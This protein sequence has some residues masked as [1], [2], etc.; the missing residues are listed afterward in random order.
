MGCMASRGRLGQDRYAVMLVGVSN[1]SIEMY[2]FSNTNV[3]RNAT[4]AAAIQPRVI[5]CLPQY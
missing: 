5:L 2:T 3:N 4:I 1:T